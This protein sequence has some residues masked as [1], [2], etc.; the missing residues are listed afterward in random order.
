MRTTSN[1]FLYLLAAMGFCIVVNGCNNNPVNSTSTQYKTLSEPEFSDPSL[2]AEHGSLII[3][4]LEHLNSPSRPNSFDTET[5]GIDA[6]PIRYSETAERTFRLDESAK[7][8]VKLLKDPSKEEVFLLT[9]ANP[10]ITIN[11]PAG[12]YTLFFKSLKTYGSDSTTTQ[13]VFFRPNELRPGSTGGID[14]MQQLITTGRCDSCEFRYPAFPPLE[15]VSLVG[16]KIYAGKFSSVNNA[17][18]RWITIE[19]SEFNKINLKNTNLYDADILN[20]TFTQVNY[21]NVNFGRAKLN[22]CRFPDDGFVGAQFNSTVNFSGA[23][24]KKT[25]L[26][27]AVFDHTLLQNVNFSEGSFDGAE[28]RTVDI[29]DSKFNNASIIGAFFMNT[30]AFGTDFCGCKSDY[31]LMSNVLINSETKCFIWPH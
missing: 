28:F 17:D 7:F 22:F 6:I 30:K 31:V 20:G 8:E 5:T 11:I 1:L 14:P 15:N 18:M 21:N 25:N 29:S 24:F 3:I 10:E 13:T 9:P 26:G 2:R 27:G 23:S 12:D 16:A 4:D 19:N